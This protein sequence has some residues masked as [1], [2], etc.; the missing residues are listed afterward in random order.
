MRQM[1][2]IIATSAKD[3]ALSIVAAALAKMEE[4]MVFAF[5]QPNYAFAA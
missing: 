5:S 2:N 3:E 1:E 4:K